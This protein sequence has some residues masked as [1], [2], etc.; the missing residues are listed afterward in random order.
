MLTTFDPRTAL[1]VI[2]LQKGITQYPTA[3]PSADVISRTAEL[4][5]VFRQLELPVVLVNVTGGAPG[6]TESQ[7]AAGDRPA[8]WADIL[9][10]LNAQPSDH[11]VTK[12]TWG[13]FTGT[14]LDE[15]LRG[16]GVT[17]VVLTGIATSAGVE[18]TARFAH[19]LGY[20]VTVATDA[21]T[22]MSA[23]AHERAVTHVFPRIGETGSTAEVIDLLTRTR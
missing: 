8:D 20:N 15:Y 10:Q 22:D 12:L 7:R 3:H 2:D 16:E 11:R 9:P 23:D 4:A 5:E 18:S 17:Q 14:D 13:A 1:V 6:R 19:E 21:V